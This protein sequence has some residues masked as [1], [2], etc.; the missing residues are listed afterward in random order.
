MNRKNSGYDIIGAE[1]TQLYK[2][3]VYCSGDLS[4]LK[5]EIYVDQS[6]VEVFINDGIETMTANIYPIEK[7]E[8]IIFKASGHAEILNLSQWDISL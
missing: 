6:S 3:E 5:L 4:R 2:R 1:E 8:K 7:A